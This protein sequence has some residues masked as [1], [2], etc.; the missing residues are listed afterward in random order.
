MVVKKPLIIVLA[1]GG[2]VEPLLRFLYM[3]GGMK[4][5]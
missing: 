1:L 5:E 4:E 3:G 2:I